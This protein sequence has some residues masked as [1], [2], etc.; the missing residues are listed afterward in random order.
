MYTVKYVDDFKRIHLTIARNLTELKFLRERFE[1][2]FFEL[3][4]V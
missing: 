2:L 4:T 3:I 1:I